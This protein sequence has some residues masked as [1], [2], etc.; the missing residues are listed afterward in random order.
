M[1]QLLLSH[2]PKSLLAAY[3]STE[4]ALYIHYTVFIALNFYCNVCTRMNKLLFP[5]ITN[6]LFFLLHPPDHSLLFPQTPQ[7]RWS[8]RWPRQEPSWKAARWPLAAAATQTR[9]STTV[10]TGCSRTDTWSEGDRLS[11]CQTSNPLTAACIT[12]RPGT[13][14][15]REESSMWTPPSSTWMFSVCMMKYIYLWSLRSHTDK[16]VGL[17]THIRNCMRATYRI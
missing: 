13:T 5:H 15:A 16:Q 4:R 17:E 1:T 3:C 6:R 8:C 7:M 14:W 11:T 10:T 12:V 9:L 2:C